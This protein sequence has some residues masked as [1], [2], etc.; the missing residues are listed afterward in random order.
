MLFLFYTH[1]RELFCWLR[2]LRLDFA[3]IHCFAKLLAQYPAPCKI[4]LRPLPIHL[5]HSAFTVSS[6]HNQYASAPPTATTIPAIPEWLQMMINIHRQR[7]RLFYLLCVPFWRMQTKKK[8]WQL[9]VINYPQTRSVL[10]RKWRKH[11]KGVVFNQPIIYYGFPI[12]CVTRKLLCCADSHVCLTRSTG[13]GRVRGTEA[14][15]CRELVEG[16]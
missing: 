11:S 12:I 4:T 13:A 15:I 16:H 3:Q 7:R 9:Q 6:T 10:D 1:I 2:V 14:D 5:P 8:L